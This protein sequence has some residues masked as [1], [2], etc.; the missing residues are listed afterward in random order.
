MGALREPALGPRHWAALSELAGFELRADEV[1]SMRRLI[2]N[3]LVNHTQAR[4]L[5]LTSQQ[6][7]LLE[8]QCEAR[9][10]T[11]QAILLTALHCYD[12]RVSK[13]YVVPVV[14]TSLGRGRST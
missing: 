1:S 11:L 9:K 6:Q 12:A 13:P 7:L 5:V 3:G 2:E 10:V 14:P 4:A 8:Y